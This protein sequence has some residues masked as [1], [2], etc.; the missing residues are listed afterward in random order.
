MCTKFDILSICVLSILIKGLQWLE[1]I[2]VSI[3]FTMDRID[4]FHMHNYPMHEWTQH[5]LRF[6]TNR[7]YF[8]RASPSCLQRPPPR[9][10]HT[11]TPI[12]P[13][14]D[15]PLPQLQ[16]PSSWSMYVDR[17]LGRRHGGQEAAGMKPGRASLHRQEAQTTPDLIPS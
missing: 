4:F 9:R 13:V 7:T 12:E 5:P 1:R 16:N 2:F 15:Q 10:A 8:Q 17:V 6:L 14:L 3:D 11:T